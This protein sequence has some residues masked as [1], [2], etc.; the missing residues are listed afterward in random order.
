VST[1]DSKRHTRRRLILSRALLL[2]LLLDVIIVM[3]LGN[4]SRPLRPYELQRDVQELENLESYRPPPQTIKI[5]EVRPPVRRVITAPVVSEAEG[6][7]D[8][9]DTPVPGYLPLEKT[10]PFV[11]LDPLV[12]PGTADT[13]TPARKLSLPEPATPPGVREFIEQT[14]ESLSCS[15]GIYLSAAGEVLRVR[16]INSTGRPDA[17]AAALEAARKSQWE[18]ALQNG[19]PIAREVAVT[20]RFNFT[21]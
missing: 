2:S 10:D 21:Q 15:V 5:P 13:T 6:A 19:R 16:I 11:D 17:D 12:D 1:Q 4:Y 8:L 14:G 18:P 3:A 20:Y 9:P 7:I